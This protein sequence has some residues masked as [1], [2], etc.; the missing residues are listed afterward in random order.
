MKPGVVN[1]LRSRWFAASAHLVFWLLVYLAATGLG[2][3]APEF[4]AVDGSA[5]PPQGPVAVS[6]LDRLFGQGI[7]PNLVAGTNTFN[8]FFTRH[9]IPPPAPAPPPPTTKKIEL[10]YQGYYQTEGKPTQTIVKMAETF[11]VTPVGGKITANLYAAAASMQMLTLT[12]SA[13][14]TNMLPLN[15]KKELEVPI[16]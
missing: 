6:K 4:R 10:T 1:T 12:N 8:P 13:A 16:Q 5:P 15:T 11:L 14:Q 9:F 7:W 3:K 2:G